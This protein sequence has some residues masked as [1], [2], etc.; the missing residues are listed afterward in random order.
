VG[1]DLGRTGH[2]VSLTAFAARMWNHGPKMW[3]AMKERRID[4]PKLSG[5]DTADILAYL[6]VAHY[7]DPSSSARRGAKALADKG[8]T[9]CHSV[10]GKGGTLAADLATSSVVR[11]PGGLVAGMWNHA[12]LMEAAAQ[13]QGVAWPTL[14]GGDLGDIA[15]Y[16][17]A[18]P[19]PKPLT[20]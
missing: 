20:K 18:L 11:T 6:Y 8:C 10:K 13:K 1:P 3:A 15:A 9:Q 12:G 14:Q 2:H 19:R 17:T 7:F 4:V 5:Q 16:L